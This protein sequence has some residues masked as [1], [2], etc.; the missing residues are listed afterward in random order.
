MKSK[1]SSQKNRVSS[2]KKR[3]IYKL[4]TKLTQKKKYNTIGGFPPKYFGSHFKTQNLTLQ[5]SS[6]RIPTANNQIH[7]NFQVKPFLK[8]GKNKKTRKNLR[9]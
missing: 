3:R 5:N 6:N 4:K 1:I 9:K 8:G 7:N 2:Q